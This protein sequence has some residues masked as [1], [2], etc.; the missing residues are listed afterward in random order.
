[1]I[2]ERRGGIKVKSAKCKMQ[3]AKCKMQNAKCKMQ[4]RTYQESNAYSSLFERSNVISAVSAHE[5]MRQGIC[6]LDGPDHQALTLRAH[7]C[8]DLK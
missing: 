6:G 8:E 4:R 3:N 2:L 1:M 7:S 5:H